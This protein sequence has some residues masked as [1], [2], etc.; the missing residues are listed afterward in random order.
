MSGGISATSRSTVFVEQLPE[1]T[2]TAGPA[3]P[4]IIGR[5]ASSTGSHD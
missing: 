5:S 1:R 2:A 4:P 3:L